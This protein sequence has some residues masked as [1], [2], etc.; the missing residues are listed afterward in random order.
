LNSYWLLP[1]V[2]IT[3]LGQNLSGF[4]AISPSILGFYA[5]NL[6]K[7]QRVAVGITVDRGGA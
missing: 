3:F 2:K 6:T 5:K 7:F 4:F 1:K